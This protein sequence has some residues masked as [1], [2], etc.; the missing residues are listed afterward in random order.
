MTDRPTGTRPSAWT[1]RERVLAALSRRVPDR[2]PRH[3]SLCPAQLARLRQ[4]TGCDDPAAFAATESHP[5]EAE[6]LLDS[7]DV[8]EFIHASERTVWR[9]FK[10]DIIPSVKRE[11]LRR[12]R[13][14][15]L[16][17]WA[18]SRPDEADGQRS[19]SPVMRLADTS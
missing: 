6:Q 16:L 1:P 13:R 10:K 9:Y 15:D 17:E 5:V 19:T 4:E 2:V 7:K 8:A 18:A 14:S 12:V 11:G 3:M